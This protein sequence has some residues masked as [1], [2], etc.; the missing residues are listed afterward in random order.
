MQ[1]TVLSD[2]ISSIHCLI[3]LGNIQKVLDSKNSFNSYHKLVNAGD[4]NV[5]GLYTMP[6]DI[7]YKGGA[8]TLLGGGEISQN[9]AR[10]TIVT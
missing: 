2:V 4:F 6:C 10:R 8:T 3:D 9:L 5:K 7:S 1:K